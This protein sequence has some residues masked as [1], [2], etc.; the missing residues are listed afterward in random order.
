MPI[1]NYFVKP[2]LNYSATAWTP[3]AAKHINKL[4]AIQKHAARFIMSDFCKTTSIS[5]NLKTLKWKSIEIQHKEL[6]ILMM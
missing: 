6:R 1:A 4:E 2:I 3:N 5:D